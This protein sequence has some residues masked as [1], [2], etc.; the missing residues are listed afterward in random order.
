[1]QDGR[2]QGFL[3]RRNPYAATV[4]RLYVKLLASAAGLVCAL[5]L[6]VAAPA[7]A[8][9]VDFELAAAGQARAASAGGAL[10][11]K[12]LTT[13][14][15]F[16]LVGMR[17]RGRAQAD[18]EL[19]V[20]SDG[21]WSRWAHLGS[22]ASGTSDPIWVGRAGAVQ[23]RL[24]PAAARPQA[25]L[26][27]P[28]TPRAQLGAAG[29][30][31][32]PRGRGAALPLCLASRLGRQRLPA[33]HR[34]DLRRGARRPRA[35]HGLPQRLHARGGARD[36]AR[37]LPLPSQLERLV[38]HRLQHARRQV[39]G[40]LRGAG[41][42]PRQGR[43]RRPGAGIQ[44]ADGGHLQ[45]R[46]LH[47]AAAD[48]RGAVGDGH[49]HPLEAARARP[50]ALGARDAH[51]RGRVGHQVSGGR[52]GHAR[53]RDRSPRHRAHSLPRG[54]PLRAARRAAHAG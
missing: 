37:G 10:V 26:R 54:G 22:H 51:E 34:A 40:A 6:A 49:L 5:A 2:L 4:F 1:M 12:Q 35:P 27:R 24:E 38:R 30:A 9:P 33:S 28:G 18:I 15:R 52:E 50:T 17:W 36:R 25:A 20:R 31:A 44:R 19:R 43:D 3:Q 45:H 53:A 14:R 21:R 13:P 16:N 11:S 47:R 29:R 8:R 32:R 46:R 41:G 23:Y 7:T 48:A 39:R 42:R